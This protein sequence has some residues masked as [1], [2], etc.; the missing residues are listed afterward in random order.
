MLTGV[1]STPK[2]MLGRENLYK[3]HTQRLQ[4]V[5]QMGFIHHRSVVHYQ[6]NA[7]VAEKRKVFV[8]LLCAN[9]QGRL[10]LGIPCR[11]GIL[12]PGTLKEKQEQTQRAQYSHCS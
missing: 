1:G 6:R 12:S 3:V 11:L 9:G 7:L 2:S 8:K 4:G 5:G 10:R